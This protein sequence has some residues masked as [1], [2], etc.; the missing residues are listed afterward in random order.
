MTAEMAPLVFVMAEMIRPQPG[1]RLIFVYDLLM[2][3]VEVRRHCAAQFV[4]TARVLKRQFVVNSEG[5]VTSVRRDGYAI[6]G[7]VWQASE[8][9]ALQ[10][11]DFLGVP[12]KVDRFGAFART[13]RDGLVAVEF[14]GARNHRHGEANHGDIEKLLA[15]VKQREFPDSYRREIASWAP[16]PVELDDRPRLVP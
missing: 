3:E 2:D 10:L 9:E 8:A 5:A 14:Y 1:Y 12:R 16:G 13:Q 4:S 7:I 6:H 15:L 11:E